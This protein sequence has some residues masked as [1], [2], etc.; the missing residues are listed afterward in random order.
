M[1]T[2]VAAKRMVNPNF[3]SEIIENDLK[4]GR[5]SQIVTRFPPEPNGFAHLGHAI[6][7]YIDFG[8]AH[9][10]GGVCRLRFDDTNPET[11]SQEYV[12]SIVEDMRWL[13]WEWD[14]I[15]FASDYFEQLYEMAVRLIKMGKAY[16]DSVSPE[17][18]A[19]L[20][21]SV[22]KPGT[23]S[24]YRERSVEENLEL[25]ER[26]RAGEFPNGAHVLRAKIDLSS[27]NMKLRDP[28]LYRIVHA[29]HYRTG[30]KWCIYPSYDFAQATSDALDGVTHSLCSLEFVD[31]RAIYDWLMDH[32][33]GHP[34]LD[35]TPRPHQYEFGRRSLEYTVVSKRKLKKLV[36][37][38]YV[39]GWDDPRMPTLAGQR[40]RG[41]TPEAIR[42]FASQVGISRTNRT[43]DIGLLEHA[44]RDDLNHRAPRVM[45]VARP[46]KVVLENLPEGY[47]QTLHLAYWPHD[48]VQES[49]DGLVALPGGRRVRPEEATRP[50]PFTRELYIEQDDFAVDPPP[51]FKRLTHGGTVRLRG[52]GVIRCE[53]FITSETGEVVELRCTLL[54][55]GASAKGVIH[56]VSA[57]RALPAEFRLYDR[58]FSVPHPEAEA[59]EQE[60]EEETH[61]DR[62]FL[63]FVNP[64]S[65]EVT[66]GYVEPS[67]AGDPADTR[68]QFE[69][70]GYFWRDPVD[71]RPEALVF[72]RIV[73]LKDTWG[74]EAERKTPDAKR[75]TPDARRQAP[76]AEGQKEL[77]DL[78]AEQQD[79]LERL[80]SQGVGEAEALVL[81]RDEKLAAYLSEAARHGEVSALASWVVNDLGAPI[82]EERIRIA[83]AALARLVRL[84]EDGTINTRIAKDVLAEAQQSGADPVEIVEAKGLRQVS[85]AGALEPILERLM[86]EYPDKVAAYRSGKTGLMGFFVGQVMRAT[87]GRAN[88]QLV[89]ELV[90]KK[91]GR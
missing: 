50:V 27:P 31:N 25:F 87:Q 30:R 88:P 14:R 45:A 38:G 78:T 11:E 13:G 26:M 62:D 69:R 46:L 91:L 41:V 23:P 64:R 37:G 29:E 72:N 60:E 9:D 42:S 86:A 7:S 53:R 6:A 18:M 76:S 70:S 52:A 20:R 54:D 83:P 67:I 48:V 63:R 4:T 32:L 22:D 58:L 89:Q 8:L 79:R 57:S 90:A 84:L 43:V 71:S 73:T 19:R 35:K 2:S 33:W 56:W 1:G 24:P 17:E 77:P 5:Y 74:K 85:E 80:K 28:V 47:E 39:R 12:D 34:P 3:I 65:L 68:Y 10:Y 81:A 66:H 36:A 61:E 21:G 15:S 75:K 40:R 59:K 49:P 82:R 55:E 16:V 44:I 51:G